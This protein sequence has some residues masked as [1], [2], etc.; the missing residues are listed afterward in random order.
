MKTN[1]PKYKIIKVQEYNSFGEPNPVFYHVKQRKSFLG[2]TY[3]NFMY[4]Y[5]ATYGGGYNVKAQFYTQKEAE[6]FIE[7]EK[8]RKFVKTTKEII[9]HD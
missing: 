1:L 8:S 9:N 5:V 2:I 3:W 6:D 4:K 7:I